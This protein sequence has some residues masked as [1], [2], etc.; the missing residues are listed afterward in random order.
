ME[1]RPPHDDDVAGLVALMVSCDVL[2]VG[3]PDSDEEDVLWRWRTPGFSKERDAVI[4]ELDGRVAGYALTFEGMAEVWVHPDL[5]DLGIGSVLAKAVES[6]AAARND[7]PDGF[8]R[9]NASSRRSDAIAFLKARGYEESHHYARMEVKFEERPVVPEPP[10]GFEVRDYRPGDERLAY[11]VYV[12]A[13]QQYAATWHPEGFESW[14]SNFVDAE[15]FVPELWSLAF[16]DDRPVGVAVCLDYP[17]MGWV[18]TLGTLPEARGKGLGE[19][20]LKRSFAKYFDRG[21]TKV[22][23]TVSSRNLPEAKRLY[24]R[25]G[26]TEVLR[27]INFRKPLI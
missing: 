18:Q 1:F 17:G 12:S 2:D 9:Q 20:L 15:D 26:M 22:G 13:W 4:A 19:V 7:S 6:H 14:S 25:C 11:E 10:A 24:E 21:T 5:R 27:Y 23:L 16:R 8:L 3:H